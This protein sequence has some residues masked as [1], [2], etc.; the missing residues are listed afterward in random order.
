MDNDAHDTNIT[1]AGKFLMEFLPP[2]LANP[3][4]Y[5]DTL[6]VITWDEDDYTELNRVNTLLVGPNVKSANKDSRKYVCLPL[7]LLCV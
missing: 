4:F 5:K 7:Y 6:V 2:L 1:Y 3:A